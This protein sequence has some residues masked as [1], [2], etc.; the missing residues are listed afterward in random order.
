MPA[1]TKKNILIPTSDMTNLELLQLFDKR[2]PK[3]KRKISIGYFKMNDK[4]LYYELKKRKLVL[5]ALYHER[6]WKK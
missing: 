6:H 1:K 2:Y 5:T 3:T 4:P